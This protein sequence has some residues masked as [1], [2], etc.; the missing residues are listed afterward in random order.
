[1]KWLSI[2][3]APKD[4]TWILV[5]PKPSAHNSPPAVVKWM[6]R[7]SFRR[8]GDDRKKPVTLSGWV[9]EHSSVPTEGYWTHWQHLPDSSVTGP[10]DVNP[11]GGN[12]K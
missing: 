1:M 7:D 2:E 6:N 3:T 4:G 9:T 5:R 11:E 10:T 12:A 8:G